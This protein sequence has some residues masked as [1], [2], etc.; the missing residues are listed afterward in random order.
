MET[1]GA[2]LVKWQG[3]K[4]TFTPAGAASYV[5]REVLQSVG[6]HEAHLH[7]DQTNDIE[8]GSFWILFT[9]FKKPFYPRWLW[10]LCCFRT[11]SHHTDKHL[12]YMI[13]QKQF[14]HFM[15]LNVTYIFLIRFFFQFL[16]LLWCIANYHLC[17]SKGY[18]Y[19]CML[20]YNP[21]WL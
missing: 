13:M 7:S 2:C 16:Y 4:Y 14:C 6:Q 19:W 10:F 20:D 8:K 12:S 3:V 5:D 17:P 15:L 9:D 18:I 1:Q 11:D 21:S